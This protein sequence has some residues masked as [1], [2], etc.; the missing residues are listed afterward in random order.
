[1]STSLLRQ[2]ILLFT[3]ALSVFSQTLQQDRWTTN[4]PVYAMT[5]DTAE[6]VVYIGGAFSYVGPYTGAFARL[7]NSS[8]VILSGGADVAG[9]VFAV[10]SDGS[11]GWYVGG[12]FFSVGGVAQRNLAHINA[13]GTLDETWT[14]VVNKTVR[15][16]AVASDRIY[17]GGDFDTVGTSQRQYIASVARTGGAVLSWNPGAN[18]IVYAMTLHGSKLYIGGS[19]TQAGG[20]TRTRL[21]AFDTSSGGLDHWVATAG[22]IVRTIAAS[23]TVIYLGGDFTS[24]NSTTRNRIAAVD[25]TTGILQTWNPN[26]NGAIH[27]LRVVGSR[28]YAGGSFSMFGSAFVNYLAAINRSSNSLVSWYPAVNSTVRAI[29]VQGD[30]MHIGGSFSAVQYSTRMRIASILISTQ[31][32]LALNA[33]AG[34]DVYGIAM[35]TGVVGFGG[36]FN[37]AGGEQRLY[38]AA[39]DDTTGDL[40]SWNPGT[41]GAVQAIAVTDSHIFIGGNFT[42]CSGDSRDGLATFVKSTGDLLTTWYPTITSSGARNIYNLVASGTTLFVGGQFTAVSGI[43]RNNLAKLRVGEYYPLDDWRLSAN[44][45]IRRMILKGPTLYFVGDFTGL[46]PYAGAPGSLNRSYAAA[47]DTGVGDT[48][49][50]KPS[51][52]AGCTVNDIAD[53]DSVV[54]VG[55]SFGTIG[56]ISITAFAAL[57]TMTGSAR[58]SFDIQSNGIVKNIY[59]SGSRLY[60]GGYFSSIGGAARQDLASIDIGTGTATDWNV[61]VNNTA[62]TYS[63]LTTHNRLWIGRDWGSNIGIE[64]QTRPFAVLDDPYNSALPVQLASFSVT[65]TGHEIFLRWR[66]ASETNSYS[67]EIERSGIAKYGDANRQWKTVSSV[68]AQGNSSVPK[69]YSFTEILTQSGTYLYRLKQ[70]DRDGRSE[71][72]EEIEVAVGHS[73]HKFSLGQNYPNPFNPTTRMEFS[74]SKTDK[75]TLKVFNILGEAVATLYDAAAEAGMKHHVTFDATHLASGIYFVRLRSGGNVQIKKLLLVR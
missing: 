69:E 57:D 62:T 21:A 24:V 71:Y 58:S 19:F 45:I 50:W 47:V 66:T 33:S 43:I 67:F 37:I 55:G 39:L 7:D 32:L 38:V 65:S 22:G 14:P 23:D 15:C 54:Y 29:E 5:H 36:T 26:S 41:N 61:T 60:I 48:T 28:V 13:G 35:G 12:S 27:V 16:I 2:I 42:T 8:G 73:P 25:T 64:G 63:I 30:T 34:S 6:G 18:N 51:P 31:A 49:S 56:G 20:I 68:E 44:A 75:T 9:H 10:V 72:S 59:R 3:I 52:N 40:L 4:G 1:M 70:V 46:L 53:G 74:V 11:G 17:I